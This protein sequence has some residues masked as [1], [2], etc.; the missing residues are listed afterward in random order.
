MNNIHV[1]GAKKWKR[2]T[3]SEKEQ[4]RKRWVLINLM[5]TKKRKTSIGFRKV[6][7]KQKRPPRLDKKIKS[8]CHKKQ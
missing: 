5:A 6:S 1:E 8:R 7:M 4:Y 2:M 3:K